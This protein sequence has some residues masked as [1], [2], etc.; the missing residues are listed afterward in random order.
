VAAWHGF[1]AQVSDTAAP[2]L[3]VQSH[4]G[5]EAVAAAYAMVLGGQGDPRLG[6]MLGFGES[7]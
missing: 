6:H 2:W 5:P 1:R 4:R 3:V 7:G